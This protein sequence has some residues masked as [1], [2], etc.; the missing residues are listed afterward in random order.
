MA[1][2]VKAYSTT[3]SI[4]L[5][6]TSMQRYTYRVLQTIQIKIILLC[7]WEEQAVLGNAKTGLKFKYEIQ[8]A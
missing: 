4:M 2:V 7:V 6:G 8:I 5:S 3:W 1:Y